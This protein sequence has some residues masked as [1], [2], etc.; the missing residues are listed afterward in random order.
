MSK[1]FKAQVEYTNNNHKE[2]Q[3]FDW[4][5][6][7]LI[8]HWVKR[9]EKVVREK[10]FDPIQYFGGFKP[11][12]VGTGVIRQIMVQVFAPEPKMRN[13]RPSPDI[14]KNTSWSS[15][16]MVPKLHKS[17]ASHSQAELQYSEKIN[18]F[19]SKF[20]NKIDF[21]NMLL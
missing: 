4:N 9:Q 16:K 12:D 2:H 15:T 8:D 5:N 18:A 7:D 11:K 3:T 14:S 6:K 17:K 19:M 21:K 10:R 20:I 1:I 13:I